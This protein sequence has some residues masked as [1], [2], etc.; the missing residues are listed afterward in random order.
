MGHPG[1][2]LRRHSSDKRLR[3]EPYGVMNIGIL[4]PLYVKEA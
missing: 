4:E 3:T 1:N 2:L